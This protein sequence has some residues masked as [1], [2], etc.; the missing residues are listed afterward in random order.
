MTFNT[1]TTYTQKPVRLAIRLW[2]AADQN[3]M[4]QVPISIPWHR[5]YWYIQLKAHL[6]PHSIKSSNTP[7]RYTNIWYVC[8]LERVY[9]NWLGSCYNVWYV[10][11]NGVH[12][13]EPRSSGENTSSNPQVYIGFG[14]QGIVHLSRFVWQALVDCMNYFLI[15]L[16]Y[17]YVQSIPQK[18]AL[19][20]KILFVHEWGDLAMV[21]DQ[22]W[23]S[24]ANH[25]QGDNAKIIRH[26]L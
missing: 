2:G 3:T 22:E 18:Y 4:S 26:Y 13:P 1:R 23:K 17:I 19:L 8:L 11:N 15:S 10:Y 16:C 9:L 20:L 7:A 25:L 14:S 12:G 5:E 6:K 21:W 24:S